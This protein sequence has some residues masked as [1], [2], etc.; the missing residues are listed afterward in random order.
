MKN[1]HFQNFSC[2]TNYE[3]KKFFE[4]DKIS[5]NDLRWIAITSRLKGKNMTFGQIG[6]LFSALIPFPFKKKKLEKKK[7]IVMKT[8]KIV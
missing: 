8:E 4:K 7:I 3:G 1:L 2:V 6:I 5:I